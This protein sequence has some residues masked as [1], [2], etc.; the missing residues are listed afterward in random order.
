MRVVDKDKFSW[1][2]FLRCLG[3][4]IVHGVDQEL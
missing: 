1:M 4:E 3:E 2:G